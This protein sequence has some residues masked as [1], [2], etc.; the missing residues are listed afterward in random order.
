MMRS[1]C[2]ICAVIL[3]SGAVRDQYAG[4]FVSRAADAPFS[5]FVAASVVQ[6]ISVGPAGRTQSRAC[7]ATGF[8]I[9]E[10]GFVVTNAHVVEDARRCL[11]NAPEA[12]ILAK[13]ATIDAR[14]A[15]AVPCNVIALDTTNDLALLRAAHPFSDAAVERPLYASLDTGPVPVGTAVHITGYPESSWLPVTQSG[16]VVWFGRAPLAVYVRDAAASSDAFTL[17]IHLRPGNSGSPV[18]RPGGGI[19]GVVDERHPL[20]PDYSVAVAVRYV[21]DLAQHNGARWHRTQ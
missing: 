20:R 2:G 19:I 1:A 11:A 8:L 5:D 10:E 6:L 7:S 14:T 17:D 13:L 12:R 18:Y 16:Q 15:T 4:Q 3:L 21:I 9:D